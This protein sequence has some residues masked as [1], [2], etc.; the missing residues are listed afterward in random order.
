MR[1]EG[2]GFG[3]WGE[4]SPERGTA[5]GLGGRPGAAGGLGIQGRGR[6]W[7]AAPRWRERAGL[8]WS[9][10][11][12]KQGSPHCSRSLEHPGRGRGGMKGGGFQPLSQLPRLQRRF[13]DLEP[14][15]LQDCPDETPRVA[16]EQDQALEAGRCWGI[17]TLQTPVS[18]GPCSDTE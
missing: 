7:R 17:A 10:R 16:W 4:R 5:P 15:G 3:T 6:A 8:L 13:A 9:V 12:R 18:F 11:K 14:A 2:G 1:M